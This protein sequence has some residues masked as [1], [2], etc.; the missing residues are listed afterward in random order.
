M[1]AAD[2]VTLSARCTCW[3]V[4]DTVLQAL[5]APCRHAIQKYRCPTCGRLF[6]SLD[7]FE[8]PRNRAHDFLCEACHERHGMESALEVSSSARQTQQGVH[9]QHAVKNVSTGSCRHSKQ[10]RFPSQ[11]STQ[12]MKTQQGMDTPLR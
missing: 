11:G 8:L 12:S 6:T 10:W 3:L 1:L 4:P 7:V 9:Q 5:W 2:A